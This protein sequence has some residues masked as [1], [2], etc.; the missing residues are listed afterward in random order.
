[1]TL[2]GT[3]QAMLDRKDEMKVQEQVCD[4]FGEA[5]PCDRMHYCTLLLLDMRCM[6]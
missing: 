3:V 5:I 4:D 6:L 1:M 2:Q